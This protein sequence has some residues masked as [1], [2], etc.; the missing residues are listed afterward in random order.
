M[1]E[2]ISDPNHIQINEQQE[3]QQI[4]GE[5]PGWIVRWG[6]SLVFIAVTTLILVAYLVKYPDVIP[7]EITLQTENPPIRVPARVGG[8]IEQ[9]LVSE[10]EEVE[11]GQVLA[12]FENTAQKE[13]INTL[14]TFIAEVEENGITPDLRLPDNL[15]LGDLQSSWSSFS[16]GYKD[17]LFFLKKDKSSKKASLLKRQIIDTKQLNEVLKDRERS[18]TKNERII[19][20][21]LNR[22]RTLEREGLTTKTEVENAEAELI[23]I[24]R[25][26]ADMETEYIN[27]KITIQQLN[28]QILDL[29]ESK[30]KSANEKYVKLEEDFKKLKNEVADW[31][32]SFLLKSPIA[33]KVSF[34]KPLTE[35]QFVKPGDEVMAIIPADS[36]TGEIIGLAALPFEGAGKVERGQRVNIQLN[37]YPYQQFG[38]VNGVVKKIALLPQGNSYLLEVGLPDNLLTT[39][40]EELPFRQ[41]MSGQAK[42][43]TEERRYLERL[44]DKVTSAWKND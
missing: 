14:E 10:K 41:Q 34:S 13:S 6:I 42:I 15:I 39:Y 2:L 29:D 1:P 23:N 8:K 26:I 44:F 18:L 24:R 20:A 28:R 16:E 36:E 33:G 7:A 27:N 43:I 31:Q 22:V 37:D 5:P 3:I 12:V 38:S 9:L 35:N 17:W 11:K 32:L 30:D 21:Q 40:N 25:Q 4:M 19:V